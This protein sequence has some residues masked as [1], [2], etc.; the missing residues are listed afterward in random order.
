MAMFMSIFGISV[1][2]NG[3]WNESVVCGCICAFNSSVELREMILTRHERGS[4][5]SGMR[6]SVV[7]VRGCGVEMGRGKEAGVFE[8]GGCRGVFWNITLRGFGRG[9]NVCGRLFGGEGRMGQTGNEREG[10]GGR[11]RGGWGRGGGR[12]EGGERGGQRGGGGRRGGEERGEGRGEGSEGGGSVLVSESDFSSFCVSSAPFL[13]PP[14][15]RLVS[16]SKLTF[17]NISTNPQK[18]THLAEGLSQTSFLMNGCTFSSICDV[19]DGGIVHSL[20]NPYAS[21]TASN[22]SFVG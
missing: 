15:T 16:L 14:L 10:G 9:G 13:A 2:L 17:F 18:T 6:G 3:E 7:V 20:N 12:G 4:V 19:Y 11:V 5:V 1:C 8:L 22:T 21:L